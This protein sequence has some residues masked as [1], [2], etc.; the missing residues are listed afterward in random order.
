[1][2]AWAGLGGN[3]GMPVLS[4]FVLCGDALRAI[5][6]RQVLGATLRDCV[7]DAACDR[8]ARACTAALEQGAPA[9]D[10]G[11]FETG[12]GAEI[13]YRGDS[14]S[15]GVHAVAL[16]ETRRPR[17]PVRRLWLQGLRRSGAGRRLNASAPTNLPGV[18]RK[19]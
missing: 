15:R 6:G 17:L 1:M 3:G 19:T 18:F 8:L 7:P 9:L 11:A 13:R 14:L 4:M 5:L 12:A 2:A 16:H 10:E